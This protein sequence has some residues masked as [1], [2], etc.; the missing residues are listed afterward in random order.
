MEKE[1]ILLIQVIYSKKYFLS[2]KYLQS[3]VLSP[4]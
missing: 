4:A 2:L 3:V 1:Q